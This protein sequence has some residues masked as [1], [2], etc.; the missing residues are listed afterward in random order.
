MI[1]RPPRSTRTDTLF[2]YTTLFRRP[3]G[4][5]GRR[6]ARHRPG[7]DP[8]RTRAARRRQD[9]RLPDP[10]QPRGRAQEVRQGEGPPQLPVLEALTAFSTDG[11]RR[12]RAVRQRAALFPWGNGATG[13]PLWGGA[14]PY[15][16][17]GRAHV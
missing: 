1:R 13:G 14:R 7:T 15:N 16:E 5:G 17:I 3:V 9:G 6:S 10:R 8:L 2:P 11:W 12:G 4:P